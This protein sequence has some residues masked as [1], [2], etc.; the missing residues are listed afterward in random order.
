M[1]PAGKYMVRL[2]EDFRV[3]STDSSR[4]WPSPGQLIQG[5]PPASRELLKGL[6]SEDI[7][8]IRVDG[9]IWSPGSMGDRPQ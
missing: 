3:L 2:T 7:A 4:R 8:D 5:L 6:R 1:T 9:A